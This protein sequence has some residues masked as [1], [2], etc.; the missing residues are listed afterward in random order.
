MEWISLV[1]LLIVIGTLVFVGYQSWL[2]RKALEV[3]S[4]L[5]VWMNHIQTNHLS[6][7]FG[8][9][10]EVELLNKLTPYHGLPAE[11]ARRCH[12]ADAVLDLYECIHRLS[13]K[14]VLSAEAAR[15]WRD[16]LPYEMN[17][18][19]LRTHWR[20]YHGKDLQQAFQT[21]ALGI[22]H[23]EF[24]EMIESIIAQAEQKAHN[25]EAQRPTD[26]EPSARSESHAVGTGG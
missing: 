16:S 6:I 7:A 11:E 15:V 13:E 12:F 3:Q 20:S 26:E 9:D 17:N 4:Y 24:V 23:R 25:S 1:N 8:S 5:S 21:G 18:P 10:Q 14:G 22:Y 19:E 2:M